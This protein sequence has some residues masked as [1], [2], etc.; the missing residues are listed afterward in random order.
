MKKFAVFDIDGTLIRWQ[1]YHVIVDRLASA[2]ELA[3]NAHEKL[4]AA[5]R[6]WKNR[7]HSESFAEYEKTLIEI[8]HESLLQI[9]PSTF[10][11]LVQNVIEEYKNQVYVFTRDLITTL[12]KQK[13]LLLAISGSHVEL[14]REVANVYGFDDYVGTEY[15]RD[16]K[17]YSGQT[18]VASHHKAEIL[19]NMIKKHGLSLEGS[20]AVGD[21]ASDVPMLELVE[22]AIA[23]NP[24]RH[25]YVAAKQ[26]RW[27]I[28]I[29]RKNMI[30]QLEYKDGHYVLAQT[31]NRTTL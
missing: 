24:D 7:E 30:Y 17:R 12:K 31:G 13:Y 21:S 14:V 16:A 2:G 8:F 6:K 20:Y 18:Y 11:N 26:H 27:D 29:E 23:F 25:L 4:K 19:Q 28:V 1:L 15:E 5:R 9:N 3:P 22:R 10:D